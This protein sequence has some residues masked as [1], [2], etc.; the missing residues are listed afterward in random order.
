MGIVADDYYNQLAALLPS[1]PA[2]DIDSPSTLTKF[3]DS[4]S[5]EFGRIQSSIDGLIDEADPRVNYQ[6]LADYERVFGLPTACMSGV[7]QSVQQRHNT[8]VTQMTAIG[9]QSISYFI[10]L[11]LT[12]GFTIT[13][14]EFTPFNVGST[15]DLTITGPDWAYAWQVNAPAVTV[16]YFVV[17]SGVNE[18]LSSWGNNLLEC[19]INRFKPAHTIAIFSYI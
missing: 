16:S 5:Q 6:L 11:A 13:I 18:S 12:A 8:L 7:S 2:W 17:T 15:I 14:T 1:G 10:S 3:L 4:W 9:G 19:L